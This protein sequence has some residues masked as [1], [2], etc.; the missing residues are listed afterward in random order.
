[1]VASA[2]LLSG[3][4]DL[5]LLRHTYVNEALGMDEDEARDCSPLLR[6]PAEPPPLILARGENETDE[7]ARQ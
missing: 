5:E 3:V 4:Y 6:L 2:T 7:F 1:M